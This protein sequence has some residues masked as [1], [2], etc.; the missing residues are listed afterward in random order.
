MSPI[1]GSL[2][3]SPHG[4]NRFSSI[5]SWVHI[6][7]P[8]SVCFMETGIGMKYSCRRRSPTTSGA[9]PHPR[10]V[11]TPTL[12]PGFDLHQQGVDPQ[13]ERA[14]RE[15]RRETRACEDSVGVPRIGED[16]GEVGHAIDI[17]SRLRNS[18]LVMTSRD[19]D[20]TSTPRIGFVISGVSSSIN[21]LGAL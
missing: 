18:H 12:R 19:S 13:G 14:Q 8:N 6:W 5:R 20:Q 4:V 17:A 3:P 2:C 10:S 9:P 21:D 1:P 16:I 7:N 11:A 15:R